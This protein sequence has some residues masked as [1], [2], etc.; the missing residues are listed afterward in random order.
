MK[1]PLGSACQRNYSTTNSPACISSGLAKIILLGMEDDGVIG[2]R[3]LA[4]V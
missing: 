2:D 4:V 1:Q 3:I